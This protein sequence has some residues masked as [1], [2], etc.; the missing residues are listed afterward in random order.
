MNAPLA[1]GHNRLTWPQLPP[2]LRHQVQCAAGSRVVAAAN[3]PGG[4]SPGLASVLHLADGRAVFVKAA[5]TARNPHTPGMH[6]QE[7]RMLAALPARVPAPRLRWRYDDGD[8]VAMMTDAVPG[9]T[10]T[11]PWR[12]DELSRFIGLAE[13]LTDVLT[14]A[15][16]SAPH[17]PHAFADMFCGW[18]QWAGHHTTDGLDEWARRR[19][20][21]LAERESSATA[22]IG[23]NTL[24]HGDLRAD[25]VL[26][27][28][29]GGAV[30]VD[31]PHACIGA[32]WLDLLLALPSIAMHGGGDPEQLWRAYRPARTADPDEVNAVLAAAVGFFLWQGHQPPPPNLAALR[33]FQR[34]QGRAGLAWLRQRLA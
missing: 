8:W 31:W 19:L 34:A 10:P 33:A 7:V 9:H 27:S 30:A 12:E 1:V 28:R 22:A 29:L 23:G 6:R 21:T 14:P 11:Q 13:T 25:N 26:L 32:A 15:P 4:F 24:L 16:V 17:A 5:N 18:R 2:D 3:Q 20:D